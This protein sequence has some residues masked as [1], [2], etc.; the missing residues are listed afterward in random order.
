MDPA[1]AQLIAIVVFLFTF[2]LIVSGGRSRSVA[3]LVGAFLMVAAG[4]FSSIEEIVSYVHIETLVVLFGIMVLV[5]VLREGQFFNYVAVFLLTRVGLKPTRI[6]Y[7]FILLTAVLS[8]FLDSVAVVL[9]MA[10][11]TI[12]LS[13]VMEFDPK[14]L[15]ITEIIAANVAGT[16][17]SIGD[18]P[19]IMISLSYNISFTEFIVNMGPV[20]VLALVA[21]F[22]YVRRHYRTELRSMKTTIKRLPIKPADVV[23]DMRTFLLG[24]SMFVTFLTLLIFS[25]SLGISPALIG[26]GVAAALLLLGGKK[27][28][29]IL[30]DVEWSTLLFFGSIFIVVGGLVKTGVIATLA[31]SLSG[32]IGNNLLLGILVVTWFSALGSAFVGNIPFAVTMLPLVQDIASTTG[33]L[34]AP[35]LWALILGCDI[36]GNATIIGTAAGVVASDV[37]ERQRHR[38]TYLE[39]LRIG[40]ISVLLTVG[41]GTIYL[42]LR[43]GFIAT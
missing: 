14:P 3:G 17:T 32:T 19:N 2:A 36:G 4:I 9:F 20:T 25:G 31:T 5:G 23:T 7:T 26:F 10:A 35:M 39:Y 13:E 11:V 37:A 15:I 42:I 12:Q 43:Y 18:P 41:L 21:L 33:L 1:A 40:F 24:S 28:V 38:I 29:F 34:L 22:L 30:E 27:L 16:A 6:F 8:A